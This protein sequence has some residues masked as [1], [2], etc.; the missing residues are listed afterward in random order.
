MIHRRWF[1][2]AQPA[3]QGGEGGPGA[4]AP[5]VLLHEGLGSISAW[6]P[7]PQQLADGTGRQVLAFDRR[8]YGRS[9]PHPGPWPAS[10][11]HDEAARLPTLLAEEGVGDGLVLIGHSDGASIALLYPSQ[12]PGGS[13][14]PAGIVSLSAH[15]FVEQVGVAAIAEVTAGYE[16]TGL[17]DRLARHHADADATFGA[18][19]EVWLSDRFRAWVLDDDVGA[20]TCPVLAIQGAADRY[21]TRLQLHRLSA[22]ASG[23]V[24]VHELAGVD[25]WP[26]REAT[27]AV[28]TLIS[29]FLAK[30]G[31]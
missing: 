22:A 31:A 30:L 16:T 23:P 19:S 6:G 11:M 10:Y 7:F 28:V 25:H 27:D 2:P 21:G 14:R 20:V 26:H 13:P 15:L 1:E 4:G 5:L 8:G 24:E 3:G 29:S 18:W 9:E 12:A 17:R